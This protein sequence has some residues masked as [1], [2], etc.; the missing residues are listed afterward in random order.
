M[1]ADPLTARDL[2]DAVSCKFLPNGNV[3]VGVHIADVSYY[4]HEGTPLDALVSQKANT[5]YLV[6]DVYHMLPVELCQLCSLLPGKDSLTFSVF[7]EM[8]KDGEIISTRFERTVINSCCQLA[9]EHA[10]CMIDDPINFNTDQLPEIVNGFT[11]KYISGVVNCLQKIAINLRE[12]RF[13]NGALRIDQTKLT[14]RYI[15]ELRGIY[16]DFTRWLY[17]RLDPQTGLPIDYSV[18]ENKPAHRLIEEFMLLANISV[19]KR[20]L[21]DFPT[22]ALLRCHEGPNAR[23]LDETKKTLANVGIHIDVESS[24]SLQSSIWKYDVDKSIL[25]LLIFIIS[26]FT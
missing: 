17:F 16:F 18:Y 1:Y 11:P 10:Q 23:M 5:I 24:G 13:R 21:N 8:T 4:L 15:F 14:F 12:K 26:K 19:A 20:I 7:W 3:D 6:N 22:L 25:G 9:Y 2:D